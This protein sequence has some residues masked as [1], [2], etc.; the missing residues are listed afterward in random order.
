MVPHS[1]HAKCAGQ[2]VQLQGIV[3]VHL[4][5]LTKLPTGTIVGYFKACL[6]IDLANI[7][8][9]QPS[10]KALPTS[11]SPSSSPS[12]PRKRRL[13]APSG[14]PPSDISSPKLVEDSAAKK[15]AGNG[16]NEKGLSTFDASL[17]LP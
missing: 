8:Y 5:P 14:P 1:A 6:C 12:T 17:P 10:A 15:P 4:R 11:E 13:G 2:L 3:N 16:G 7:S 9:L